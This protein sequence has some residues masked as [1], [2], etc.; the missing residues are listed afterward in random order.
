MMTQNTY[1]NLSNIVHTD[2][3]LDRVIQTVGAADP[4][5]IATVLPALCPDVAY[6]NLCGDLCE[7]FLRISLHFDKR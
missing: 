4:G 7:E 3:E 2:F 1:T 6:T 5:I